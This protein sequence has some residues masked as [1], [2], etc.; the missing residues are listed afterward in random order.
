MYT[1]GR[2]HGAYK[3]SSVPLYAIRY[4][5]VD[6]CDLISERCTQPILHSQDPCLRL[7]PLKGYRLYSTI[8]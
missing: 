7:R 8:A 6:P 3:G 4:C 2:E 5:T 1:D